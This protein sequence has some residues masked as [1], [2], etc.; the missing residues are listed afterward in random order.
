MMLYFYCILLLSVYFSISIDDVTSF[1][2]VVGD[3]A[4]INKGTIR[5]S[6]ISTD[7]AG[8]ASDTIPSSSSSSSP[9]LLSRSEELGILSLQLSKKTIGSSRYLRLWRRWSNLGMD[10]IRDELQTNNLPS[11]IDNNAK[12]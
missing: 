8:T 2:V 6:S 11:P 5:S 10:I 1:S 9:P 4:S 3:V 12:L 7:N